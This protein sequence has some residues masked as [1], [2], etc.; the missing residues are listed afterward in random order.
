MEE[1]STGNRICSRERR[2]TLGEDGEGPV[3][4]TGRAGPCSLCARGGGREAFW[5]SARRVRPPVSGV[6]AESSPLGA[7]DCRSDP[8]VAIEAS[9]P[10]CARSRETHRPIPWRKSGLRPRVR[11]ER[12]ESGGGSIAVEFQF[13]AESRGAPLG[14]RRALSSRLLKPDGEEGNVCGSDPADAGGLSQSEGA[15]LGK[16]VL[17]LAL[18]SCNG[19]VV[20]A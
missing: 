20:E 13:V 18:E 15:D 11:T 6:G 8:A 4:R 10:Q 19:V 14:G 9:T 17:G 12:R 16:A 5:G 2:G 3:S 1:E 7:R